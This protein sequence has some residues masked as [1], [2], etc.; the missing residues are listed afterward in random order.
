MRSEERASIISVVL[1]F[2]WGTILTEPLHAFLRVL[3]SAVNALLGCFHRN[4]D[5]KIGAGFFL[6]FIV[7]MVVLS[8]L[9][10][11]TKATLYIPCTYFSIITVIYFI[12]CFVNMRYDLGTIIALSIMLVVI[13]L[14][15]AFKLENVLIWV[16]DVC[17]YSLVVFA[18]TGLVFLPLRAL[19]GSYGKILYITRYQDVNFALPFDGFMHL[20]SLVWGAFFAVILILPVIYFSFSRI[21]KN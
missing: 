7:V 8:L 12:D 14:L 6:I 2:L 21:R 10:S 17:I 20:P 5:G 15:H 9:L 3:T 11:K 19:M 1:L 13:A 16:S 4:I 18:L